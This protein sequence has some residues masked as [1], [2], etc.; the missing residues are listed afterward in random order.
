MKGCGLQIVRSMLSFQ[1]QQFMSDSY[2][3]SKSKL[4]ARPS[5]G[6]TKCQ[7][8][9]SKDIL[10]FDAL[11][12]WLC[13]LHLILLLVPS[14]LPFPSYPFSFPSPSPF[15][16]LSPTY[17]TL[18]C[19]CIVDLNHK[20]LWMSHVWNP[21]PCVFIFLFSHAESDVYTSLET[22]RCPISRF[23]WMKM[24]STKWHELSTFSHHQKPGPSSEIS[25][26][27]RR[28]AI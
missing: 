5:A 27:T 6:A 7:H 8:F 25:P 24:N 12:W 14:L 10:Q 18:S 1:A 16:P 2:G 28:E 26:T 4:E 11:V 9:S 15:N 17:I 21:L 13:L 19:V 3:E 22:L 20:V 23:V